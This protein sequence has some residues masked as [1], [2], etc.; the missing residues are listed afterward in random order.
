MVL[1]QLITQRSRVQIPPPPPLLS[2]AF[3]LHLLDGYVALR[4][5]VSGGARN[6]GS[7]PLLRAEEDEV[8]DRRGRVLV[9]TGD[10]MA[11]GVEGEAKLAWPRR[12]LITLAE[13]PA[14]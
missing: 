10:D 2:R 5:V 1:H 3:V 13:T 7:G 14:L 6:H 8:G 4:A 9:H 12:P 11:V